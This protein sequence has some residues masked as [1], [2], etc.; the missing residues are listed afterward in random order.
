MA[1]GLFGEPISTR[2]LCTSFVK[3]MEK[4]LQR[5]TGGREALVSE[6]EADS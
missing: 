1:G 3:G 2:A 4:V 5:P 6:S